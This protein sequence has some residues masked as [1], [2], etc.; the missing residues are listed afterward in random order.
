MKKIATIY[1]FDKS[2]TV[3]DNYTFNGIEAD[4]GDLFEELT[5]MLNSQAKPFVEFFNGKKVYILNLN[6]ILFVKEYKE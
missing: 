3:Y 6:Q 1:F 5:Y 2:V 4:S